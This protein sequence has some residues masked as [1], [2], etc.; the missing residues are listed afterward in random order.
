MSGSIRRA[1]SMA[2]SDQLHN[3]FLSEGTSKGF[4]LSEVLA[5]VPSFRLDDANERWLSDL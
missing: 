3:V 2:E 1:Q 4:D 5:V